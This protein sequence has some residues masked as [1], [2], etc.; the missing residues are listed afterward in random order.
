MTTTDLVPHQSPGVLSLPEQEQREILLALGLDMRSPLTKALLL[1]AERYDLDPLLK[2]VQIIKGNVYITHKGLLHIAHASGKL[3]GIVVEDEWDDKDWF[4]AKVSVFRK[5]MGKPFTYSGKFRKSKVRSDGASGE[6]MALK[7]AERA[8]LG[9]AFDVTAPTMDDSG[10]D[11]DD[12]MPGSDIDLPMDKP[13]LPSA[14]DN[15]LPVPQAE[16]PA[17]SSMPPPSPVDVTPEPPKPRPKAAATA[18]P[19]APAA[20]GAAAPPRIPAEAL[21]VTIPETG[22]VV[23]LS[24]NGHIV[25]EKTGGEVLP[26][27]EEQKTLQE[28]A[29]EIAAQAEAKTAEPTPAKKVARTVKKAPAKPAE[30]EYTEEQIKRA[31]HLHMRAKELDIEES[32]LRD[33]VYAITEKATKSTREVGKDQADTIEAIMVGIHGEVIEL[34]YDE[35]GN[36]KFEMMDNPL[37]PDDAEEDIPDAEIVEPEVVAEPVDWK[38]EASTRYIKD[39]MFLRKARA[40]AEELGV[41]L[42]A[43][44][45]DIQGPELEAALWEWL[46]EVNA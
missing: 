3:D 15:A 35:E 21:K 42:P 25:N 30:P 46:E 27:T 44:F 6:E 22:E 39:G 32:L 38:K 45:K 12:V 20:S 29:R 13:A 10:Q 5:D 8:A 43:S 9:R 28:R 41:P 19:S 4:R 17:E 33:I 7:N 24:K 11:F 40:L 31:Q 1:V 16:P 14:E 37:P 18:T 36:L 23:H 34:E 2:Q 26:A